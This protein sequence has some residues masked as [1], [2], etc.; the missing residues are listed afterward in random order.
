MRWIGAGGI[1]FGLTGCQWFGITERYQDAIDHV[2]DRSPHADHWYCPGLDVSR[3]NQPDWYQ[4]K[5]NQHLVDPSF[6]RGYRPLPTYVH[7]PIPAPGD[8]NFESEP[9]PRPIPGVDAA[10]DPAEQVK[11]GDNLR[12]I[13][14]SRQLDETGRSLPLPPIPSGPLPSGIVPP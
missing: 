9:Q 3:I 8:L 5:W 2:A 11:P 6:V 7:N 12:P 4:S 13:R 14:D 1:L 10:P